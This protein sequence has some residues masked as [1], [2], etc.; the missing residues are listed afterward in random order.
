MRVRDFDRRDQD[1]VRRLILGGLGEHWGGIDEAL[2]PDLDDIA[3]AYANGRTIV[4]EV[5]E[6]V[7]GTGTVV[8]RSNA[9][10]EIVRM[11]VAPRHRRRAVGRMIVA[12]LISTAKAWSMERVILETSSAWTDV[13]A[14]YRACGF[15]ITGE[16]DGDF[17]P[18][19]WLE[20]KLH[21]E[22]T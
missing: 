22:D 10:V 21:A 11:S 14:F 7:I 3:T 1:Q 18:D 6:Q 4:V 13:V 17:G 2:N 19:T 5:D 16:R 12:E 20:T 8:R 9:T 15:E